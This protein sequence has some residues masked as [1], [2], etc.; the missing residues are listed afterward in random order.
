MSANILI[1]RKSAR[2]RKGI[3]DFLCLNPGIDKVRR[4]ISKLVKDIVVLTP[5]NI[6]PKTAKS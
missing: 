6:T 2:D 3:R 4:V 1:V 5:A